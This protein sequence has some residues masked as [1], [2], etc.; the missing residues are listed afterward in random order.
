MRECTK[1]EILLDANENYFY[2][3]KKIIAAV[4]IEGLV[5]V[6]TPDALLIC[7][8]EKSQQVKFIVDF[9][10]RQKMNSYI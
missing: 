8:K 3:P 1:K 6:D 7:N 5:V 10:K 4:D 9:L 2:S